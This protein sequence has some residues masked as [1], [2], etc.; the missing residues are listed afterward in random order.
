MCT[1]SMSGEKMLA[2]EGAP[3]TGEKSEPTTLYERAVTR[4][5]AL[6]D[7]PQAGM[8]MYGVRCAARIACMRDGA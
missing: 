3:L 5:D 2:E 8:V 6:L 1:R 7:F 4:I